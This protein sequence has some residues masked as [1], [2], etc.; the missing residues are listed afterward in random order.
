MKRDK[1]IK[2][3]FTYHIINILIQIEFI[4]RRFLAIKLKSIFKLDLGEEFRFALIGSRDLYCEKKKP[5]IQKY[6]A[7][8]YQ[9]VTCGFERRGKRTVSKITKKFKNH[10]DGLANQIMVTI[11]YTS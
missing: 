4:I 3:N 8:K 2:K 11:F 9:G 10:Y 6:T 5:T 7:A 1:L